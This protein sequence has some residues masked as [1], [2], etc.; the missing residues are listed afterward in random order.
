MNRDVV[1]RGVLGLFTWAAF[2]LYLASVNSSPVVIHALMLGTV[3]LVGVVIWSIF[4]R[5]EPPNIQS[6]PKHEA[7]QKLQQ[8]T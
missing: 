4:D 5:K 2:S 8:E 1:R 6:G 3:A 7:L